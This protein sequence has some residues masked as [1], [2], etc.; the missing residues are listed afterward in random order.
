MPSPIPN[1][2]HSANVKRI[3]GKNE[4]NLDFYTLTCII[5][6]KYCVVANF[7]REGDET[8]NEAK[9]ARGVEKCVRCLEFFDAL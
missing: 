9:N 8:N 7:A 2:L 4:S 6:L 1:N 5:V 3:G